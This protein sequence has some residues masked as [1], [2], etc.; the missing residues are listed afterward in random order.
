M[1]RAGGPESGRSGRW[2][3]VAFFAVLLLLLGG[4]YAGGYALTN[5]RVPR[6]VSVAGIQIGG[7]RPA[8]ARDRLQRRLAPRAEESVVATLGDRRF[9]IEPARAG[10]GLDL[11]ATLD[12][13]GG[14]ESLNPLRM[15]EALTGGEDVEPVVEV[16]ET[17]L[18]AAVARVSQ[19]V[20]RDPVEGTVAFRRGR[21]RP[22][23]PTPG[24]SLDQEATAEAV[25]DAFLTEDP[26]FELPVVQ[27]PT[28]LTDKD[29][30]RALAR[31]GQPAMS[32]P[33]T[34][35]A[36]G[37]SVRLFPAA[38]GSALTMQPRDGRLVPRLDLPQLERRAAATLRKLGHPAKPA[39]VV[40]RG[41]SPRVVRGETGTAVNT[42]RLD[43]RLLGVLTRHGEARSLRLGTK[44]VKPQF[45]VQDARRLRIDRVVSS[46]TTY[47]PH[48]SYRNNNLG[49]AAEKINGTVLRPGDVFSLNDVVGE[50][51]AKNGFK[52]GYIIDDGVLVKDF[53]GGVSQV[54]TTT[55]NAAFFAGLKDIEHHPHSLYF[56]RY[57]MGREA[58]VAWGALDLKF[59][60]DTPHGILIETW[61]EP[62]SP[63]SSGEM[64]VR[65]W[66]T[67][68]WDIRAGLSEQYDFT[69]PKTRYMTS[70]NC[71]E[72]IGVSG[73]SVDVYRY[74]HRN[75]ERVRTE[76]EHVVYDAAD[77]VH[78]R[79]R[80]R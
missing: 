73:F 41:G 48:S 67:K 65:M 15:V 3:A 21:A 46:F 44:T 14:G 13:A 10:L 58:T 24:L 80:P 75:G 1:R 45:G 12:E 40:L 71:V 52:K 60:N 27:D 51:T 62:S 5:N 42:S 49:R 70:D 4:L 72:Q 38:I 57:P 16:D 8:A 28:A 47:F 31:F 19:K 22:V 23:Y 63:S 66:G 56:D 77:T 36:D 74:F 18:D 79:P 17:A 55:Y 69:R 7:M 11:A 6:D 34:L 35:R 29:V 9:G 68:H 30:D 2:F 33:V 78:C 25:Q 64:H 61:I 26:T 43:R 54:A 50:R 37:R 59:Q 32:S 39:T 76:K 20:R 53:G